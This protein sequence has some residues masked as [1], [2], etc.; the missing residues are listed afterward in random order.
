MKY[1]F[2]GEFAEAVRVRGLTATQL[3][4]RAGVAPATVA[5]A[6]RGRDLQIQTA[7][8]IAKAVADAPVIAALETWS[9]AALEGR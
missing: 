1:R 5:A 9:G 8:R 7:M 2:S 4:Q 6:L 3:A